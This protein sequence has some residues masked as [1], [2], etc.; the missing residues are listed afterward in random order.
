MI[1]TPFK[2]LKK[3]I[4]ADKQGSELSDLYTRHYKIPMFHL[5]L[6]YSPVLIAFLAVG[7]LLW[8]FQ[9]TT[10][11]DLRAVR[12]SLYSMADI[13]NKM[14]ARINKLQ[15]LIIESKVSTTFIK[16]QLERLSRKAVALESQFN[17]GLPNS[18][19]QSLSRQSTA[20]KDTSIGS[21]FHE[22]RAGDTLYGI[23]KEYGVDVRQLVQ[24]NTLSDEDHIY[25]GQK[26]VI[27][28]E[29]R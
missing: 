27:I 18:S 4:S 23:A 8:H 9:V 3:P 29:A 5:F 20:L 12:T 1:H 16:G 6:A 25:P 28:R 14:N 21:F 13:L 26:I 11:K 17:S 19:E 7:F 2:I 15:D 24:A 10:E 22:V